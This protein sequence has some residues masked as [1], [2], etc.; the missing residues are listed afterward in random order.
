M[1]WYLFYRQVTLEDARFKAGEGLFRT[2]LMGVDSPTLPKLIKQAILRCSMDMR[3]EMWQ[4]VYLGGGTTLLPSFANRLH[5]ELTAIA[6]D[7]IDVQ[8]IFHLCR[9]YRGLITVWHAGLVRDEITPWIK[10]QKPRP[11]AL[12]LSSHELSYLL[13]S[14]R[15][16]HGQSVHG[17]TTLML[18]TQAILTLKL[19]SFI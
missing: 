19:L 18:G 15:V 14:S 12:E 11:Q 17:K 4:S 2:E 10:H 9:V 6:P 8:V 16:N 7:S 13:A 3:R 5:A 1:F